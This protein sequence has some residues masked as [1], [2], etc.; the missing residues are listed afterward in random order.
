MIQVLVAIGLKRGLKINDN[1]SGPPCAQSLFP[2]SWNLS[3]QL[4]FDL[5]HQSIWLLRRICPQSNRLQRS[6]C[7]GLPRQPQAGT[8]WDSVGHWVMSTV[9][10]HTHRQANF[11][12]GSDCYRQMLLE[13]RAHS[14]VPSPSLFSTKALHRSHEQVSHTGPWCVIFFLLP[15]QNRWGIW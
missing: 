3:S 6:I 7:Q 11:L 4:I 14:F 1:N 13:D 5:Q 15:S 12:S 8:T 2:Q 10:H 9:K